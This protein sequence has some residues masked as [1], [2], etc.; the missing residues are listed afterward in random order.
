MPRTLEREA[1]RAVLCDDADGV[2]TITLNRPDRLNAVDMPMILQLEEAIRSADDTDDVH[3][4]LL[5]GAGRAFCAG[6]DVDAQSAICAAGEASLREQL[7]HLQ[8]ISAMLT[9]GDKIAVAEVRG[10]A[11]GAGFSW[12]LNCDFRVWGAAAQAAFPEIGLGTFVT[13][14]ATVLLPHLAGAQAAADLLFLGTRLRPS[15]A[16]AAGLVHAIHPEEALAAAAA[17]LARDLAAL[18]QPAARSMKR[19]LAAGLEPA[20]RRAL[21]AETAACVATTLD[22]RTLARMRAAI[23]AR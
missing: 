3:V 18:P 13:G 5:R 4:L 23:G 21:D 1:A 16:R 11:I 2:R 9:L 17:Q 12:V 22:P 20:F 7:R 14:G 15:E 8:N 10:W 6:D 19:A